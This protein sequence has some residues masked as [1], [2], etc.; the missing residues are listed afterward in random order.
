MAGAT[1]AFYMAAMQLEP[2]Q[3]VMTELN[4]HDENVIQNLQTDCAISGS[5]GIATGALYLIGQGIERL[6]GGKK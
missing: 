1:S 6:F 4:L 3:K 2:I 5:I